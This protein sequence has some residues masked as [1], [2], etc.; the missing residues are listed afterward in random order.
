MS[1][2]PKRSAQSATAAVLHDTEYRYESDT[3]RE[4]DTHTSGLASLLFASL[5]CKP[6]HAVPPA[7]SHPCVSLQLRR[8]ITSRLFPDTWD[9]PPDRKESQ[10]DPL[11]HASP[12]RTHSA[13]L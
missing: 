6:D 9:Y 11:P 2:A 8:H 3:S 10:A 5:P 7:D 4:S 13:Q 1:P 12:R